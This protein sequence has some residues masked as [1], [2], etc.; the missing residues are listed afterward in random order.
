MSIGIIVPQRRQGNHNVEWVTPRRRRQA[1]E[2]LKREQKLISHSR[3]QFN[4]T[5][6]EFCEMFGLNDF[7]QRRVRLWWGCIKGSFEVPPPPT[8]KKSN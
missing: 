7:V 1:V 3:F 2:K 8:D 4:E 6:I 5:R